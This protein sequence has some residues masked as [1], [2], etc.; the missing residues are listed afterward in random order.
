MNQDDHAKG[1]GK[2][3]SNLESL[4]LLIRIY[5]TSANSQK[6]E[7]PTPTTKELPET[8]I[9]NYMPLDDLVEE[10]NESLEPEEQIHGVNTEVVKIRDA[11]AHGRIF[12]LTESFPVTI[13]KFAKPKD[14]KAAV[15]YVETLTTDW[16]KEKNEMIRTQMNNVIACGK[17]RNYKSFGQ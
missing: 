3:V 1:V 10:Y 7:F 4:E 11:L 8:Y 16:L 2:I 14:G 12:S 6:I 13:Y 9:T 15:D 17:S 5:L